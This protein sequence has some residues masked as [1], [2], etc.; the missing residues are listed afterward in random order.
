MI[1][2]IITITVTQVPGFKPVIGVEHK[3]FNDSYEVL[4]AIMVAQQ[5]INQ[6]L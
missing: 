3:D 1:K 6:E 5:E 2:K 4:G